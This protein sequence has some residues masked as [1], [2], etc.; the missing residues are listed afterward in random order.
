M[1][2]YKSTD[3]AKIVGWGMGACR[4]EYEQDAVEQPVRIR[5]DSE[6]T[7]KL[8]ADDDISLGGKCGRKSTSCPGLG[9]NG[10]EWTEQ[11]VLTQRPQLRG[12]LRSLTQLEPHAVRLRFIPPHQEDKSEAEARRAWRWEI[13]THDYGHTVRRPACIVE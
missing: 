10:D 9:V 2:A 12:S 11:R 7:C 1:R 5:Q 6:T 3:Q 8:T 13:Y 4:K